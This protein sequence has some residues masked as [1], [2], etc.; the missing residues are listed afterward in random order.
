ME[1][2]SSFFGKFRKLFD[3][4]QAKKESVVNSIFEVAKIE[5]SPKDVS[6]KGNIVN[7]KCSP[8]EKTEILMGRDKIIDRINLKA[9]KKIAEEI[10]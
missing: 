6:F 1:P 7:I 3:N 2:I 10:F 4:D 5:I 9:K 8:L